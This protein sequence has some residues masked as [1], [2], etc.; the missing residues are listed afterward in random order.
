MAE[1]SIKDAIK[2]KDSEQYFG[3]K[4]IKKDNETNILDV[5]DKKKEKILD[6]IV[7][8]KTVLIKKGEK[9]EK[10]DTRYFLTF[11]GDGNNLFKLLHKEFKTKIFKGDEAYVDNISLKNKEILMQTIHKY[12]KI[13][14]GISTKFAEYLVRLEAHMLLDKKEPWFV[15]EDNK[16]L[17]EHK[18]FN[19]KTR[20]IINKTAFV[21]INQEDYEDVKS[22]MT[23]YHDLYKNDFSDVEVEARRKPSKGKKK[24]TTKKKTSTTTT[25]KTT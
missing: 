2:S 25:K 5:N 16:D 14:N 7:G 6:S 12:L 24:T 20:K 23:K 8:N 15:V 18:C 13:G 9:T 10:P 17:F 4:D 19:T 22:F 21:E 1:Q 11:N 3:F